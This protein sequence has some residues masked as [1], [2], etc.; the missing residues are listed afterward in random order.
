M[1]RIELSPARILRTVIES[2]SELER[3]FDTAALF[4]IQPQLR[5]IAAE[6]RRLV[7]RTPGAPASPQKANGSAVAQ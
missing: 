2:D 3:D 4:V 5:R 7:N 1:I 6:L